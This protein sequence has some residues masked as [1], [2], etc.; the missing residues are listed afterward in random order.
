MGCKSLKC[1]MICALC[2]AA[3]GKLSLGVCAVEEGGM[4]KSMKRGGRRQGEE[5]EGNY[6][7]YEPGQG[8]LMPPDLTEWV[9]AGHLAHHVSDLMD[10][11]DL[12]EFY[13]G[14]GWRNRPY[15]PS[16]M[17]KFLR[18]GYATGVYASRKIAKKLDEDVAFRMLGAGNYPKHRTIREFRPRE[19]RLAA[20]AAAKKRLEE[21]QREM[22]EAR[23]GRPGEERNRKGGRPYNREYGQPSAKAESNFTDPESGFTKIS[24]EGFQ[25]RY[26]GQLVLDGECQIIVGTLGRVRPNPC[27][28]RGPSH[29]RSNPLPWP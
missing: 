23:G 19:D 11:L 13:E 29:A 6:P 18:Y 20:I 26:N 14:D 12:G 16:M 15:E 7:V 24:G 8:L 4:G 25:Q 1:R 9:P 21:A 22:D 27:V 5:G 3:A 10:V 17:L 28:G 2:T